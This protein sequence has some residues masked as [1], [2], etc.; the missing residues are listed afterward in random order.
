MAILKKLLVELYANYWFRDS[1]A[2]AL[3]GSE[4]GCD[5]EGREGPLSHRSEA[6]GP[7]AETRQRARGSRRESQREPELST[8]GFENPRAE[9]RGTCSTQMWGKVALFDRREPTNPGNCLEASHRLH[10]ET[11][12]LR[13]VESQPYLG[14]SCRLENKAPN[15]DPPTA[16]P[17]S[18]SIFPHFIRT[19]SMY[20][21]Y[22]KIRPHSEVLEVKIHHIFSEGAPIIPPL[23]QRF[24]R[25]GR[26]YKQKGSD[27]SHSAAVFPLTCSYLFTFHLT[28]DHF[29]KRRKAS[30]LYH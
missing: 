27:P 10:T 8:H 1:P 20:R 11:Q 12:V 24:H 25:G 15:L 18:E 14:G 23:P 6:A 26:A 4:G 28:Q 29:L 13:R 3:T 2:N 5:E 17:V 7:T 16:G 30:A 19:A 21:P 9:I 22:L